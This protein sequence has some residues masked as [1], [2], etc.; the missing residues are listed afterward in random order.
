MYYCIMHEITLEYVYDHDHNYTYGSVCLL[1]LYISQSLKTKYFNITPGKVHCNE[2]A[3]LNVLMKCNQNVT[4]L[5]QR[6]PLDT[7][8]FDRAFTGERPRL[9]AVEPQVLRSMDQEPFRG[10]SYTNPNA[11]D[12]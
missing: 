4:L 6:H 9:T 2:A 7:Q 1:E 8:Y 5:F 10:F 12:R 11:T 3:E